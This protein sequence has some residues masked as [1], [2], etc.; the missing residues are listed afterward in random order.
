MNQ[1]RMRCLLAVCLSGAMV[2]SQSVSVSAETGTEKEE[3]VYAMLSGNGALE[4]AYVVNSFVDQDITDYGDYTDV[5]NLTTTDEIQ[6]E[7]GKISIRTDADKL[8]YQGN[9][10]VDKTELPWNIDVHY[11]MDGTE[12]SADEIAGKSGSLKIILSIDRNESCEN[13]FW[14]GY[15]LQATMTLDS[16]ICQNIQADGATIA[17]VGSDKQLSYIILP[18]KGD[19]LE[20]KADVKEFEMGE[21]SINGMR[22][23]L[24]IDL[25]TSELTDQLKDIKEAAEKLDDGAG[26]LEDGTNE[27]EDGANGLENGA[28]D[29]KRGADTLNDGI[30]DVKNALDK[31]DNKSENLTGGSTTV[32]KNLK[33]IETSLK[34][35]NMNTE[36]LKKLSTASGRIKEG[37]DSLVSGLQMVDGSIGDYY[38]ALSQAGLSDVNAFVGQH[39]EAIAALEI[40]DAGRKLVEAYTA[41]GDAGVLKKLEE[42]VK[43]GDADAADLYEEYQTSGDR[44]VISAYVTEMGKRISIESLLKADIRYIQGSSGLISGIDAQLDRETGALMKGA[45][46]LQSSYVEFDKSIQELTNTL[47]TL[48][49]N[50]TSLK[51]GV[52]QLVKSYEKLDSGIGEYTAGVNKIV[53]GYQK[54]SKGSHNLVKGTSEL[55]KGTNQLLKGVVELHTGSE[56]MHDGTEE[57]CEKTKDAD[58]KMQNKVDDKIEEMTGTGIETGSFVSKSNTKVDS[59]LFVMK[60]PA[61]E[62]P[63]LETAEETEPEKTSVLQ[64]FLKLFS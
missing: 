62:M 24:N 49:A 18:G 56:D 35:I 37:I 54:L 17:N 30:R 51:S 50:M 9:L 47:Q 5:R 23:N 64:K 32:L 11:F 57:F 4:G 3:V 58:S 26:K 61:I 55:Y 8:Y 53:K 46:S 42:L 44:S 13:S 12:Y 31:L 43:Q 16:S 28:N 34:K 10:D 63:V 6:Y 7:N 52:N 25:D 2:I 29:L 48:V 59:V 45:A 60:I 36:D 27:L 40:T 39:D 21:I 38:Q 15:A 41:N 14:Q 1:K 22:L 19:T 33:K 20:I